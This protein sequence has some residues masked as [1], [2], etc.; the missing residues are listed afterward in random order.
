[1]CGSHGEKEIYLTVFLNANNRYALV[2]YYCTLNL[3]IIGRTE[4][5]IKCQWNKTFQYFFVMANIFS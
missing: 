3:E 5:I 2:N 1:M 4:G